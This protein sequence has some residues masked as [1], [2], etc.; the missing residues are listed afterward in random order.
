VSTGDQNRKEPKQK[1]GSVDLNPGYLEAAFHFF[2][3]I[4]SGTHE[5]ETATA[6]SWLSLEVAS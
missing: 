1:N 5:E 3:V 4:S 6:L 2:C